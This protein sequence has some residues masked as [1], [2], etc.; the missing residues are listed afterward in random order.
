MN[1]LSVYSGLLQYAYTLLRIILANRHCGVQEDVVGMGCAVAAHQ[2]SLSDHL[3]KG[4]EILPGVDIHTNL[5]LALYQDE[6]DSASV[7]P[8]HLC[9]KHC[10]PKT[11]I[12]VKL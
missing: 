2:M 8:F 10:K 5:A 4:Q 1:G 7:F 6:L 11:T 9:I 12:L 3:A